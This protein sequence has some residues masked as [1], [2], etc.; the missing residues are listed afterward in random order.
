MSISEDKLIEN[1]N[2]IQKL[3]GQD[4]T[5]DLE[6]NNFCV[7]METG[8]G[9]T[10]VYTKTIFELNKKYGFKKFI[11]VVP[12]VAIREGVH[13]SLKITEEHFKTEYGNVPINYF[14]YDSKKLNNIRHFAVSNNIEVMIINIQSF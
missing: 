5:K 10:Y 4:I 13:K 7:E 11:I 14:I 1:M 8:T 2:S 9:K 12:S 3:N 6:N